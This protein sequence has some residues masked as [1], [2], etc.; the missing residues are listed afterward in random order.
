MNH[1]QWYISKNGG[2]A[3]VLKGNGIMTS[4]GSRKQRKADLGEMLKDNNLVYQKYIKDDKFDID[5]IQN[6]VH[7]YNTGQQLPQPS[8]DNY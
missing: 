5:Q 8:P 3:K 4:G 6:L 1:N 7:W 2:V